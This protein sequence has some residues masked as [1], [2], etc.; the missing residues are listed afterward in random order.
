MVCFSLT[1]CLLSAQAEDKQ[2]VSIAETLFSCE[3]NEN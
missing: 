2:A 3:Y 1:N